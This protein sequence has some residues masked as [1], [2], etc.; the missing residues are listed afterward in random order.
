MAK[1]TNSRD[2]WDVYKYQRNKTVQTIRKSKRGY[3]ELNIDNVK[4]NPVK[5]WKTI[6]ELIGN[7]KKNDRKK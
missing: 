2:D 5:M 7:K 6:K 1:Y 3:Y 4:S